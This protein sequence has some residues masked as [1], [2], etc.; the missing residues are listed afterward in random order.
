MHGR[1]WIRSIN[2]LQCTR[3]S[4]YVHACISLRALVFI[5]GGGGGCSLFNLEWFWYANTASANCP[6]GQHH[7][8]CS[9]LAARRL[10]HSI[11]LPGMLFIIRPRWVLMCAR[12]YVLQLQCLCLV[13]KGRC[14]LCMRSICLLTQN[15]RSW[16]IV[17]RTLLK[18][19]ISN[20][21]SLLLL[22]QISIPQ[23]TF[24]IAAN[25]FT[26]TFDHFLK[27]LPL[28]LCVLL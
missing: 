17:S 14:V 22:G 16:G 6:W 10:Y 4:V 2:E 12:V 13:D 20:A 8:L 28:H 1:L 23:G 27:I 19:H 9:P 25:G 3:Q 11:D 26:V 7:L 21:T 24:F 15:L 18:F 5:T